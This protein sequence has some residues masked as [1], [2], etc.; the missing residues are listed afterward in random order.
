MSG[1]HPLIGVRQWSSSEMPARLLSIDL[2][3]EY[4]AVSLTITPVRHRHTCPHT[5]YTPVL[6]S[7][8]N[9]LRT[10]YYCEEGDIKAVA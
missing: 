3:Y 6:D 7:F 2:K 5:A 8:L 1:K 9:I 4:I 10:K